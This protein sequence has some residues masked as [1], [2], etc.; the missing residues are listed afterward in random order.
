VEVEGWKHFG[1]KNYNP[2][3]MHSVCT[4]LAGATSAESE[5][6]AS[7]DGGCDEDEDPFCGG[8]L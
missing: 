6:A 5:E 2:K 4:K 8:F 7:A 3:P 1:N